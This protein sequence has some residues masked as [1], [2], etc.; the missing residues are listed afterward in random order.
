MSRLDQEAIKDGVAREEELAQLLRKGNMREYQ[1]KQKADGES[2][3][4]VRVAFTPDRLQRIIAGKKLV[5]INVGDDGLVRDGWEEQLVC[6]IKENVLGFKKHCPLPDCYDKCLMFVF[7]ASQIFC[8]EGDKGCEDHRMLD[9]H[10]VQVF[11]RLLIGYKKD[12][13]K[14]EEAEFQNAQFLIVGGLITHSNIDWEGDDT[15]PEGDWRGDNANAEKRLYQLR[16]AE[17]DKMAD[18]ISALCGCGPGNRIETNAIPVATGDAF[19]RQNNCFGRSALYF[20]M[21]GG[22]L[23]ETTYQYGGDIMAFKH[24]RV[25]G[26]ATSSLHKD[27][28]EKVK[29]LAKLQNGISEEALRKEIEEHRLKNAL[30]YDIRETVG[31]S[32]APVRLALNDD[33]NKVVT[34]RPRSSQTPY[35][36]FLE[37]L[38]QLRIILTAGC[39]LHTVY[40]CGNDFG[41]LLLP[42]YVV[43]YLNLEYN[44]R[45]AST[46]IKQLKWNTDDDLK[47][48]VRFTDGI[49]NC[50]SKD[51]AKR[52]K[53]QNDNISRIKTAID[54][55]DGDIEDTLKIPTRSLGGGIIGGKSKKSDKHK[56][57]TRRFQ[58]LQG[59]RIVPK[60]R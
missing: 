12:D 36:S 51:G 43:G 8:A 5:S 2:D 50:C 23:R 29:N 4:K 53:E 37:T 48:R 46:V 14:W 20:D 28:D 26:R 55:A 10:A 56:N 49:I 38:V 19:T 39:S 32:E 33:D 45:C 35:E 25:Y 6:D 1:E 44:N 58:V 30:L 11:R 24:Q 7:K 31:A 34:E 27:D 57:V 60:S 15:V 13:G 3:G 21:G 18:V 17:I 54:Q 16:L 59:G 47:D 9:N 42:S 52:K 22:L 41:A 40:F